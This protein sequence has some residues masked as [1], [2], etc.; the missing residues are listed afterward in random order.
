MTS[1]LPFK[2]SDD[3]LDYVEKFFQKRQLV[4][5]KSY[6]GIV[7]FID[8]D[9]IETAVYGI[10]IVCKSGVF[11][12][13]NVRKVVAATSSDRSH[14]VGDLI[15]WGA[16]TTNQKIPIGEILETYTLNLDTSTGRF[17]PKGDSPKITSAESDISAITPLFRYELGRLLLDAE[18]LEDERNVYLT[19]HKK[20]KGYTITCAWSK[21]E[22]R[23]HAGLN[24]LD[25]EGLNFVSP[26]R[27]TEI[28]FQNDANNFVFESS[29]VIDWIKY[30]I[31][32]TEIKSLRFEI[33]KT[34]PREVHINGIDWNNALLGNQ[35]DIYQTYANSENFGEHTSIEL[36]W[37]CINDEQRG[38][39]GVEVYKRNDAFGE[40]WRE[41]TSVQLKEVQGFYQ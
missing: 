9:E 34:D 30:G 29:R 40:E 5:G 35:V 11:F 28:V 16:L 32:S 17:I 13:K 36:I 6:I 41:I 24:R 20:D 8:K 27:F 37:I 12:S 14:K 25:L 15:E 38:Q 33:G 10:E 4:N 26:A 31:A 21:A 22:G 7:R 39:G 19:A 18:M 1:S 3:A 2:T 23:W